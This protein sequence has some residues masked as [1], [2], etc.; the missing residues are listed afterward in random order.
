MLYEMMT[1]TE[2][3]VLRGFTEK[4]T[5]VHQIIRSGVWPEEWV[6]PP[7]RLGNLYQLTGL[8]MVEE[9]IEQWI[10]ENFGEVPHSEK[11]EILKTFEMYWD[12]ISYRYAEMKTLE[13]YKHL[14]R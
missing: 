2:Y 14:K 9:K 1:A 11:I 3:G 6:Y 5:R 4:S 10:L 12:E 13:K 7:K 8:T